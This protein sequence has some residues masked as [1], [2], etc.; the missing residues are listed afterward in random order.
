MI[1]MIVI[2]LTGGMA[3]GKTSVARMLAKL[4]AHVIDAD[5]IAKKL[6]AP[7]QPALRL[8]AD[9]FGP[10]I[11]QPD[12]KLNRGA[13]AAIVFNDHEKL[14]KLNAVLHP[15]VIQKTMDKL[16]IF[17]ETQPDS[18]IIIDAPLLLEA[19]MTKLVDEVW[20][21]IAGEEEQIKRA[22]NRKNLS[23]EEAKK[24]LAAQMPLKEKLKYA[25]KVIDNSGSI[26]STAG[27]VKTLWE[28]VS[29]YSNKRE[30]ET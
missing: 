29:G 2:G 5:V 11:I 12:G 10:G 27:Q 19:G 4:G 26:S 24:R 22:V 6:V 25:N 13:L 21:V 15:L 1:Y 17:K 7:G 9:I 30:I 18:V 28:K 8:L 23:R 16:R 3:S 20:V 14:E